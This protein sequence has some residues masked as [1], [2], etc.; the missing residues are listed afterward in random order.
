MS[1]ITVIL[2]LVVSFLYAEEAEKSTHKKESAKN[3]VEFHPFK[4]SSGISVGY[5]HLFG[6]KLGIM[7]EGE[8]MLWSLWG[9]PKKGF[10][11]ALFFPIHLTKKKKNTLL[12][13]PYIAPFAKFIKYGSRAEL[14]TTGNSSSIFSDANV[15]GYQEYDVTSFYLGLS[16]GRRWVLRQGI[17]LGFHV[18]YGIPVVF[19]NEWE[20]VDGFIVINNDD[21]DTQI[22]LVDGLDLQFQFGFA[23]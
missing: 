12:S 19:N 18:G 13:S 17:S 3:I 21:L 2:L 14:S 10:S 11:T 5:E 8:A 4:L 6:E 15:V 20:D 16:F 23:F 22:K 9:E 7:L 1:R